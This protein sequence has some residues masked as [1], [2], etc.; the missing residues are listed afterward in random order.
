MTL[1]T[2]DCDSFIKF[3][4]EALRKKRIFGDHD[5]RRRSGDFFSPLST[6]DADPRR[7]SLKFGER[8]NLTLAAMV[9]R[10]N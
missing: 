3:E 10:K 8:V 4:S 6:G 2:K 9:K 7:E 1:L 5:P